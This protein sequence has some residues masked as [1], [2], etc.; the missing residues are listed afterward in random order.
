MYGR[1]YG[2]RELTFEA[3]G[4]LINYSLIMQDRETDT[5]WSIMRGAAIGGALDGTTLDEL[6][7]G[8]KTQWRHWRAAHPGTLVLSV[9]GVE[10]VERNHYERYFASDEGPRGSVAADERLATKAPVFS[11]HLDGRAF[12]VPHAAAEGGAVLRAGDR[13][14]FLF[15]TEDAQ[16]FESTVAFLGAAER[17]S[18]GWYTEGGQRFDEA[19][20]SFGDGADVEVLVGFDTF[21][22]HW[23][24]NNP[25]TVVLGAE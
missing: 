2:E 3:S 5:Y 6:P 16:V 20:R 10:H 13:P 17:R 12:A 24:M 7:I 9:D 18:D 1:R 8:E 4:G 23:S 19:S 11:F 25:E 14:L 21:W 22:F 15:R